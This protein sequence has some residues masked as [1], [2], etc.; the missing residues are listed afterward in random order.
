MNPLSR[1]MR[2]PVADFI[3]GYGTTVRLA[4]GTGAF[5]ADAQAMV[6]GEVVVTVPAMLVRR[7]IGDGGTALRTIEAYIAI[8]ALRD[9]GFPD[10]PRPGDRVA[11]DGEELPVMEV[12]SH[13]AG[14]GAGLHVLRIGR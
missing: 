3:A 8:S 10:P 2:G 6:P 7:S 5:D 4:R 9:T 14:A 1:L 11:V 12:E 13:A